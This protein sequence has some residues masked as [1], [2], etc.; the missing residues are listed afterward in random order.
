MYI[1]GCGKVENTF[2]V[3]VVQGAKNSQYWKIMYL[4]IKTPKAMTE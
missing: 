3:G 1:K 4:V 2:I